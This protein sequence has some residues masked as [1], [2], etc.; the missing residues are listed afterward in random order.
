MNKPH[1]SHES[2]LPGVS[3]KGL[4]RAWV[5]FWFTPTDSIGLHA[6]RMLSGL[7]FLTW[8]LG[9]AGHHEAMFSLGGWFDTQAYLEAGKV[10]EGVPAPISWSILYLAG[11]NT[12]L[13]TAI[14]WSSLAVFA[15]FTLGIAPRI[16]GVLTW[17]MVCS[18]TANPA[19]SYDGDA[20]LIVLAFY[21]MVGYLLVGW[22]N[23]GESF[24]SRLVVSRSALFLGS[25]GLSIGAN[26]TLR[27]LQVHFALIVCTSGLH[28]LQH[29]E[30]WAGYT[31]WYA[32]VRPLETTVEQ[33]S[34]YAA[35]ASS[36]LSILS[37]GA[38][39]TLAWQLSYPFFAWR[40]RW[41]LLLLGGALIGWIA[42]AFLHRLPLFG[43]AY[44]IG[45]LCFLTPAEW[46]GAFAWLTRLPGL[47]FLAATDDAT[48]ARSRR[49]E[50]GAATV[51][52]AR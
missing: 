31:F 10:P 43:P 8:L 12:A 1:M 25:S 28:K 37:L 34:E 46:R 14:Y 18:Y 24:I 33:A 17:L 26:V 36:F 23:P 15:L 16:T 3:R 32:L 5:S 44:L 29:A 27:L 30:W 2:Q 7:L 50:S 35:N 48:A 19:I 52:R 38:Y 6:V 49:K 42:T 40:P 51:S 22:E 39:L 47:G 20:L 4:V 21:L 9:F 41:R 11:E 45:S 13:L